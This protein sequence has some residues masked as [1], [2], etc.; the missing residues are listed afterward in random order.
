VG[1]LGNADDTD[2]EV[3]LTFWIDAAY[4]G[5]IFAFAYVPGTETTQSNTVETR[6]FASPDLPAA[7]AGGPA[8][9]SGSAATPVVLAFV[10]AAFVCLGLAT[11]RRR[12]DW[13]T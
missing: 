1:G 8:L 3:E 11:R 10:G 7:G 13:A 5:S 12:E 2:G 6:V 4:V 9:G